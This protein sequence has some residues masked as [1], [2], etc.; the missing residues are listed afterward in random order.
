MKRS[1]KK[2]QVCES[3][4]EFEEKY[5][6][7]SLKEQYTKVPTDARAIGISLARKSLD[8]IRRRLSK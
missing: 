4:E 7:K 3:I 2:K 5:F 6:P 8:T 1:K